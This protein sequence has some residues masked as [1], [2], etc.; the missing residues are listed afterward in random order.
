[1]PLRRT[2]CALLIALAAGGCG[3]SA[4][5]AASGFPAI[6]SKGQQ[7]TAAA[8]LGFPVFATKNTTRVGGADP[9]ADAAAVAQAVYPSLTPAS[10]PRAVAL[11]DGHDWRTALAA[12]VLMSSPIRA[13]ILLGDGSSLPSATADALKTLAP[14]GSDPAGG[15]QVV[16]IGDVARPKGLKT[17]D[18]VGA[19]PFALARAIDAFQAAARGATSADVVVA[20]ADDPAYA[21]PAAAWAAKSGDPILLTHRDALPEPTRAA[22]AAHQQPRIYVL[23]PSSVISPAVTKQLR[24]LGTVIRVGG[25]DPQS[26][27]VA[28]A[29]YSDSNF[30]WGVVDPGHGLVFASPQRPADAAAAAPLSA[31]GTYGPLVLVDDHGGLPK[32]LADY[33]LDIEPGYSSDPTRGV[34]NHGWIIGDD[35]A[36]SIASQ[37]QIDSD[38]EI[39]STHKPVGS[40]P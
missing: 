15:A 11:V 3:K 9:V 29:R 18:L 6:G 25:P 13:P 35:H 1:M 28:F 16:R 27:A 31:S 34:Y 21:M 38:L 7:S 14:T 23:G 39:V 8:S 2:A 10:R 24:T 30:G 4:G 5:G 12:S 26:N 40:Q 22:L 32:S 19:D 17:T 37:A 33:L 36:V 20:S